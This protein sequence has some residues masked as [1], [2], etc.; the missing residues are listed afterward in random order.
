[1]KR[2]VLSRFFIA[3]LL[4]LLCSVTYSQKNSYNF[5][6]GLD[7]LY[8]DGDYEKALEYFQKELSD[9]PQN[10]MA[11]F[12]IGVIKGEYKEYGNSL[13]N[14]NTAIKHIPA[15]D[16]S[17][18]AKAYCVRALVYKELQEFDKALDDYATAIKH[19]KNYSEAYQNRGQLLYEL[20]RYDESDKD[21]MKL[22][23]F[24][25]V[26]ATG[27]MGIGRNAKEQK[28]YDKAIEQYTY[29]TKLFPEYASGYSYRAEAYCLS[30]KFDLAIDDIIKAFEIEPY[31]S[32]ALEWLAPISDSAYRQLITKLKINVVKNKNNESW[33]Y[34]IG[35]VYQQKKEYINAIDN[36]KKYIELNHNAQVL[37]LISECYYK[38]ANYEVAL[39]NCNNAI[40]FDSASTY[41]YYMRSNI[42]DALGD[43]KGSI[44]DLAKCIEKE[45]ENEFYYSRRGWFKQHNGDLQ[46][47]MED[48]DI[49]LTL[50]K[51]NVYTNFLKGRALFL[52]KNESEARPYLEKV[53]ALDTTPEDGTC[54]EYALFCLG[55]QEEA[56]E[57]MNKMLEKKIGYYDVA[58]LYS[59]MNKP[60]EAL[61]YLGE[62]FEDGY[63]NF[64][65]IQR[66]SD[67]DS[68]RQLPEFIAM[69]EK[70]KAKTDSVNS[71]LSD[72]SKKKEKVIE[73]PIIPENGVYKVECTINNLPLYFIFDTGASNVSISS[74]EASF[75]LKNGYLNES[76]ISGKQ[77]Y[78]TANGEI[79]EGTV[80]NIGKVYVGT[81][82]L[83]NVKATVIHN[84]KAPILLGQ[85]VLSR[86]GKIEIDNER[87]ILKITQFVDE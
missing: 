80:I 33:F 77:Y 40:T 30:G 39:S 46:G 83:T 5:Q 25:E 21:Y 7:Y 60:T 84:Q 32:Y 76:D 36:Y 35:Y 28:H 65:H 15:K 73:I 31:E 27:Y 50:D 63:N 2:K 74:L 26:D 79:S 56:I 70:Y 1:M 44:D 52:Q 6:R 42:K 64:H 45:P 41:S 67:L 62:A 12:W 10:G 61:N 68:I 9:N 18:L 29:V 22:F 71:F 75:M 34:Y 86:L 13:T 47:A 3:L 14:L 69:I 57:W 49:A 59:L 55:R 81:L 4:C 53:L 17:S 43:Y 11:Y 58:C 82:E 38:M 54:R 37:N 23:E 78:R 8:N 66:D 51:D 19:D 16:K 85:S 20:K 48:Y 72:T 87:N 24:E